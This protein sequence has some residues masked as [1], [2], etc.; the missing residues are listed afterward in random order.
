MTTIQENSIQ[1]NSSPKD[2]TILFSRGMYI[3]FI[4]FGLYFLMFGEIGSAMS[5]FGIALIF[6]PFNPKISWINRPLYQRVWLFLHVAIVLIMIAY[7][8]LIYFNI[9]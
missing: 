8:L 2:K 5:N 9:V 4:A 1:E 6:D 3:A 7:L